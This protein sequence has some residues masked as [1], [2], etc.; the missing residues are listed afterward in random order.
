M[1]LLP[2]EPVNPVAADQF[3]KIPW[4]PTGGPTSAL[5][6][7]GTTSGLG[8]WYMHTQDIEG[9]YETRQWHKDCDATVGTT[10]TVEFNYKQVRAY[11][12]T[13]DTIFYNTYFSSVI[14]QTQTMEF[15]PSGCSGVTAISA[16]SGGLQTKGRFFTTLQGV[17]LR[18]A[19]K[20]AA[21]VILDPTGTCTEWF[22]VDL[23]H[24]PGAYDCS[25][26]FDTAKT[27]TND[28]GKILG[29]AVNQCPTFDPAL[30]LY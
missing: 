1:P 8:D 16:L 19:R 20:N 15:V 29:E 5:S 18:P 21:N 13:K 9:M 30:V 14:Q 3:N 26:G 10:P 6:L 28:F 4:D 17:I 27:R 24:N 7:T 23:A 2:P 22:N 12:T 25:S 11:V